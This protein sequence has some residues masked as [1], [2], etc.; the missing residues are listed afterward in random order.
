MSEIVLKIPTAEYAGQIMAYRRE[1]LDAGDEMDGCG[2]LHKCESAEEWIAK[3]K[4]LSTPETCPRDH[5]S[6]TQY[7]AV[8]ESDDKLVG[9]IDL[10]HH[11]DH[12]VLSMFGGH[13]GYSVLPS[14]RRK[15]YA[16]EML[17][18]CL[19]KARERGLTWVM[20]SCNIHNS[21]SERTILANGGVF[22][23]EI[24]VP[25]ENDTMKIFWIELK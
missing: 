9:M 6:D 5:I 12:P 10:R 20:I 11:I 16:K 3:V 15:G 17:R 4:K 14:E 18:Q 22:Q 24:F 7:L 1:F 13:I 2:G 23:R 25:E 19:E 21:G 8:R